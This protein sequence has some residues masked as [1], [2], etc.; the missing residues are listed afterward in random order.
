MMLKTPQLW[1]DA[2][3]RLS[4]RAKAGGRDVIHSGS[5]HGGGEMAPVLIEHHVFLVRSREERE[6]KVARYDAIAQ[7]AGTSFLPFIVPERAYAGQSLKTI[8]LNDGRTD[9]G[10]YDQ[11]CGGCGKWVTL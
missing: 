3:T 8:P 5:P 4:I 2:Q 1:P 6:A 7:G 11:Q 9:V 10:H